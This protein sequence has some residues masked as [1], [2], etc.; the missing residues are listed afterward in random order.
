MITLQYLVCMIASYPGS[1]WAGKREPLFAH[2]I[3]RILG[4]S[5][6]IVLCPYNHDDKTYTYRYIVRVFSTNDGSI[7]IVRS[8]A[9]SSS[10]RRLGTSDM[11]LKKV[12]VANRFGFCLEKYGYCLVSRC[13]IPLCFR[14]S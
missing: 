14:L 5:E 6:T 11:S 10:L 3:T 1:R 2:A 4:K 9:L 7:S 13:D 12:Q 8:P